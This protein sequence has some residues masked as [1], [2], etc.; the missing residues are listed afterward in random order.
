MCSP[1]LSMAGQ[2]SLCSTAMRSPGFKLRGSVVVV[3]ERYGRR[4]VVSHDRPRPERGLEGRPGPRISDC[5][6]VF[7]A[8]DWVGTTGL[9]ADASIASGQA[10]AVA[11][12]AAQ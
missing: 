3:A 11:A 12:L 5:P 8:G 7:V 1:Q 2:S 9:L 10:A 6:G 4:L